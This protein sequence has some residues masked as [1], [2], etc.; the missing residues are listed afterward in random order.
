MVLPCLSLKFKKNKLNKYPLTEVMGYG[1]STLGRFSVH[2]FQECT[3]YQ[4]HHC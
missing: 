2:W 3:L 4:S 1:K